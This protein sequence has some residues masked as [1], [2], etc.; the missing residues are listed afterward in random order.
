MFDYY[1]NNVKCLKTCHNSIFILTFRF[2]TPHRV[3]SVIFSV[4]AIFSGSFDSA[5]MEQARSVSGCAFRSSANNGEPLKP[6]GFLSRAVIMSTVVELD[7][8]NEHCIS[9]TGFPKLNRSNFIE[10]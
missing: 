3:K 9:L 6:T 5:R 4:Y 7:V 8:A 10:Q 2:S 1:L